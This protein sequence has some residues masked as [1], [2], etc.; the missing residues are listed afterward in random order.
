M[1]FV[2]FWKDVFSFHLRRHLSIINSDKECST[3]LQS[4][5]FFAW[6]SVPPFPQAN[7]MSHRWPKQPGANTLR[8][9]LPSHFDRGWCSSGMVCVQEPA[10]HTLKSGLGSSWLWC[11]CCSGGP[12]LSSGQP[13]GVDLLLH[14][15]LC[16]LPAHTPFFSF[17]L[18]EGKKRPLF[19]ELS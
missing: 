12:L 4:H 1:P 10:C 11:P 15:S 14:E 19:K 17:L 13:K 6:L 16:H 18:G 2:T 8:S 3:F 5:S 7:A 9:H